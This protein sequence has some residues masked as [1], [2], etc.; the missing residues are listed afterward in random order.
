MSRLTDETIIVTG[1]SRGLGRSMASRFA[2]EGANVVLVARSR[3]DLE[4]VANDAASGAGEVLVA[5]ADVTE[6]DEVEAAV[7]AAVETFG[8]LTGLVNNAAIGLLS[9]YDERRDLVDVDE[10]DWELILDVNLSGVYRCSKAAVPHMREAGR[11]TV[12]NVSSGLGRRAAAGWSPYVASKWGLEGLTRTLAMELEEDGITVNAVDPGGRV[13][14]GFWDHLPDRER[15]EI[16]GPDAMDEA[17]VLLAS[18]GP[19][20]ITGESK[21]AREWERTLE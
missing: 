11:G 13:D 5:P 3:D 12:I 17:A 7:D 19:D 18:Q 21:T 9:L 4:A 10:A 16:L 14:T 20:G 15:A 6:R 1:A 8:E 2:E